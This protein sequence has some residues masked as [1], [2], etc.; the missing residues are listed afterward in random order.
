MYTA[1]EQLRDGDK[2]VCVEWL[3]SGCKVEKGVWVQEV[4][5]WRAWQEGGS[6]TGGRSRE[7][8]EV[9]PAMR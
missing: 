8:A 1:G 2:G 6:A 5:L 7:A 4:D 3:R 9:V